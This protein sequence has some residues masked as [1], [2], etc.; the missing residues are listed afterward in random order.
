MPSAPPWTRRDL[1]MLGAGA[2]STACGASTAVDAA[3][4]GRLSAR[5]PKDAPP[6]P[7]TTGAQPLGLES[8]RDGLYYVPPG[9][10][11]PAPL[12]VLLHG[13]TGSAAGI[14]NRL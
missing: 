14:T 13:A 12:V 6:V 7:A 2:V 5:P 11:G 9:L 8:G 4:G 10:T 3:G 1:L